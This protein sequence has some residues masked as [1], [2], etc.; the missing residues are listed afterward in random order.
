MGEEV[1]DRRSFFKFLPVAP[2]VLAAEGARAVTADQ[3][4]NESN[5]T[6]KLQSHKKSD[7]MCMHIGGG[8]N[9]VSPPQIDETRSVT[10]SVGQDGHL[11]VKSKDD[12]WKRVVTE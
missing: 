3:A 9:L 8:Y 5:V 10:M 11:W 2:V 4:P 7:G 12:V 6:L 1:M